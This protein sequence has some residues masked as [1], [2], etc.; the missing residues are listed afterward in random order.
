[1]NACIGSNRMIEQSVGVSLHVRLAV[2]W[3]AS[4]PCNTSGAMC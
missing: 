4:K 3:H 2:L 1:M